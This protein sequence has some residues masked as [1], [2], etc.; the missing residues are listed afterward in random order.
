MKIVVSTHQGRLYDEEVEHVVV[1]TV[2]G[3]FAIYNKHIPVV[4]VIEDGFVKLV[5]DDMQVFV[6]CYNAVLEYKGD[7]ISV[8]AQEANIGKDAEEAMKHLEE[9]RKERLNRN[10]VAESDFTQ[11]EKELMENMKTAK[12]GHI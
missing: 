1:K 6:V 10:R 12:A 9:V 8:L 2:D 5:R 4:C 7:T 11:K 3:E